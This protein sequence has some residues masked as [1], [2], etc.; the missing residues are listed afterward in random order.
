MVQPQVVSQRS[1]ILNTWPNKA[2]SDCQQSCS[3]QQDG[4]KTPKRWTLH[5]LFHV[6]VWQTVP[7]S[8][9]LSSGAKSSCGQADLAKITEPSLCNDFLGEVS[10][11]RYRQ[12]KY[13]K[14]FQNTASVLIKLWR[15]TNTFLPRSADVDTA[16]WAGDE[17]SGPLGSSG[18]RS[19][20][21]TL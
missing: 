18:P 11:Y 17:P 20:G 12:L 16:G 9:P 10:T 15:N 14:H 2:T 4:P 13:W 6:P 19:E 5:V 3:Q 21:R 8:A 7:L 1:G